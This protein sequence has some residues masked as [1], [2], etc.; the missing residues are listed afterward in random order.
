MLSF[1]DWA[2]LQTGRVA[3]IH[4]DLAVL[5]CKNGLFIMEGPSGVHT[6][7]GD[8]TDDERLSALCGVESKCLNER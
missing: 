5:T 4:F 2:G 8:V 6:L 1:N 7:H 3:A